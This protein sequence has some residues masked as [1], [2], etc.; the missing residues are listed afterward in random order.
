MEGLH[1][2]V[3]TGQAKVPRESETFL[4]NILTGHPGF[5]SPPSKA[6]H[7]LMRF[8][9]LRGGGPGYTFLQNMYCCSA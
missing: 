8:F 6:S 9:F 2:T 5:S 1:N 4:S 7:V 3:I